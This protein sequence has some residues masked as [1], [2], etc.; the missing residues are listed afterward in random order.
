MTN[1]HPFAC[2]SKYGQ[3]LTRDEAI[4][5]GMT[6][7]FKKNKFYQPKGTL[8][9]NQV[10]TSNLCHDFYTTFTS[11][12]NHIIQRVKAEKYSKDLYKFIS[13]LEKCQNNSEHYH[14]KG[15]MCPFCNPHM[16]SLFRDDGTLSLYQ[17]L[18]Q[19][20]RIY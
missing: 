6:P 12:I 4:S 3:N 13:R 19:K 15:A 17:Q 11:G 10:L 14:L 1:Q 9:P 8:R 5:K 7:Y 2:Y 16:R 20:N 18:T